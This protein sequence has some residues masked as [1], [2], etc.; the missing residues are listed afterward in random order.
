MRSAMGCCEQKRERGP[1]AVKSLGEGVRGLIRAA[2][3]VEYP[4]DQVVASRARHCVGNGQGEVPCGSLGGG[5]VCL[6]CGCL[7]MAKIRVASEACPL[8]KW[9][10][11]PA[12]RDRS[13][14]SPS[15][16]RLPIGPP[17]V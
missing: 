11:V 4:G 17:Q 16:R 6:Q 1:G 7:A 8:G 5:L 12:V 2:A 13:G 15:S 9:G 3:R 10:A 14:P